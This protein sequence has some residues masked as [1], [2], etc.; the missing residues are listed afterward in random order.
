MDDPA[1]SWRAL[2]TPTADTEPGS[3]R[4]QRR[5]VAIGGLALAVAL[6]VGAFLIASDGGASATGEDRGGSAAVASEGPPNSST[7]SDAAV[8][9][10]EILGAVDKPGVY[11]LPTGSRVG[12]LVTAAG[13]YGPRV[14]AERAA[15]EL[16]LAA[17][18]QDGQQIRVPSRDDPVTPIGPQSGASSGAAGGLIHLSSATDTE[19][20]SLP[21]VGPVTAG[22]II[23]AREE[24]P[25]TS[26]D[27]LKTRKIVGP[28]TFEK[29]RDLVTVP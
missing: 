17:Q 11:H 18:L 24:Q 15:R 3:S 23:A 12:D 26:V 21:G 19:L 29:I 13:D 28:S 25:F 14:D 22:K 7:A 1:A 9:V 16:N 4:S 2:E 20:D 8:L 5:L 10:V 27:D 6:G